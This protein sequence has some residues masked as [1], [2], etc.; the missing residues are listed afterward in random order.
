MLYI[1]VG[2]GFMF[3]LCIVIVI[4]MLIKMRRMRLREQAYRMFM[5]PRRSKMSDDTELQRLTLK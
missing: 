2:P 3:L 4:V 5:R 1:A